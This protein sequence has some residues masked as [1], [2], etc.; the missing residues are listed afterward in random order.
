MRRAIKPRCHASIIRF[1]I[2]YIFDHIIYFIFFYKKN[3][4]DFDLMLH[5]FLW[6]ASIIIDFS[7]RVEYFFL[8]FAGTHLISFA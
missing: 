6:C 3:I 1:Q 2:F 7:V 5:L 8:Y 4:I